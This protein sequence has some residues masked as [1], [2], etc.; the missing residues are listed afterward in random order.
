V[1][2]AEGRNAM[3]KKEEYRKKL[4]AQLKEWK[5]RIDALEARGAKLGSEA[6]TELMREIGELR[7]RKGIVKEKWNELQ[8]VSGDS[9]DSMKEGVEKAVTELKGA[10]DRVISRL[11]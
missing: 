8:K 3:D 11:K 1:N 2:F 9:W 6:K 10:L 4:E 7:Q 5:A